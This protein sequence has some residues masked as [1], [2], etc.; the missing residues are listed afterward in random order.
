MGHVSQ[1]LREGSGRLLIEMRDGCPCS[2]ATKGDGD[3]AGGGVS[4]LQG[5]THVFFLQPYVCAFPLEHVNRLAGLPLVPSARK[6]GVVGCLDRRLRQDFFQ[7]SLGGRARAFDL[8]RV[9]CANDHFVK[10]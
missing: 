5:E 10:Q 8:S 6:E 3:D 7:E 2:C 4:R 1:P 9:S